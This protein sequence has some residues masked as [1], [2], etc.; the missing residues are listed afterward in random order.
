MTNERMALARSLRESART[1]SRHATHVLPAM[2]P[3]V[4]RHIAELYRAADEL[5][6]H[7]SPCGVDASR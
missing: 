6:R 5:E 7:E 4:A 1:F 2:E 3:F